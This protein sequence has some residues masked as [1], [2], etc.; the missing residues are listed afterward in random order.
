MCV[1][2]SEF[3]L[4]H[5]FSNSP[6]VSFKWAKTGYSHLPLKIIGPYETK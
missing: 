1:S 4:W 5:L 2:S 6:Q 3:V